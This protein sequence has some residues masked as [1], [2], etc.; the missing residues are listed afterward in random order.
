MQNYFISMNIM[1]M[2]VMNT[3]LIFMEKS[4]AN[5]GAWYN[6]YYIRFFSEDSS[7]ILDAPTK[8]HTK[9][10]KTMVKQ[11]KITE[12]VSH[13]GGQSRVISVSDD[14]HTWYIH[15]LDGNI[16][17]VKATW[18]NPNDHSDVS[19]E[20]LCIPAELLDFTYNYAERLI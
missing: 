16:N 20:E 3:V 9:I 6:G 18:N 15:K 17:I 10:F 19:F 11:P 5:N 13:K 12:D 14:S 1:N 4:S 7:S 8:V 2:S